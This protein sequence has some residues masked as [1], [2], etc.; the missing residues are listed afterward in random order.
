[1]KR[2]FVFA[3]LLG[4]LTV[5]AQTPAVELELPYNPDVDANELIGVTDLTSLLSVFGGDFTADP[6][7]VNGAELGA[8]I[9]GLVATIEALQEQVN[10]LEAQVV[11]GLAEYVVVDAESDL[12]QI[13][14]ANVQI[15]N[16]TGSTYAT[17]GL[18]NLWLGYNDGGPDLDRS[19]S[20]NFLLGVTHQYTSTNNILIGQSNRAYGF[21]GIVT[22]VNN[23]MNGARTAIIGGNNNT[24]LGEH[25]V[26]I[27]GQQNTASGNSA[28]AVGGNL[29]AASG[30]FA[31]AAAGY[32]HDVWGLAAGA[33]G[34]RYNEVNGEYASS[35]GGQYNLVHPDATG[36]A[37]VVMGGSNNVVVDGTLVGGK[38]NTLRGEHCVLIGGKGLASLTDIG[39]DGSGIYNRYSVIL[40]GMNNTLPA[41]VPDGR[42]LL[43]DPGT[44][45]LGTYDPAQ[46]LGE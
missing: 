19:G 14:G 42:T 25:G 2:V 32:Q 4:A 15:D 40:G 45:Y 5:S 30:T 9:S 8:V 38:S 20:H 23:I 11:P 34:G 17:N 24:T 12:V 29:N 21:D 1:M 16:A 26:V 13:T 27:G 37:S 3:S 33:F 41:D 35:F 6:V 36:D 28:V 18:G 39:E 31:V 7:L 46:V 22:G 10:A 44:I 43:G